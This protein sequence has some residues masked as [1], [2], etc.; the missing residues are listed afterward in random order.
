MPKEADGRP[1]E[2]VCAL[3]LPRC[4]GIKNLDR[5]KRISER[6]EGRQAVTHLPED[7]RQINL[8]ADRQARMLTLC[9]KDAMRL[10]KQA[11]RIG[12]QPCARGGYRTI[13]QRECAVYRTVGPDRIL[14]T[15]Q[16]PGSC[17]IVSGV[18]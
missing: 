18:N 2:L 5:V 17:Q 12:E 8:H 15:D 13:S 10:A 4:N 14:N 9:D 7:Q 11:G 16:Q 1:R 6:G 3:V